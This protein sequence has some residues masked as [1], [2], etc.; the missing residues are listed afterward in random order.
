MCP[1][2]VNDLQRRLPSERMGKMTLLILVLLYTIQPVSLGWSGEG[3]DG[4]QS[5][6]L[7]PFLLMI[8]SAIVTRGG[9]IFIGHYFVANRA[10]NFSVVGLLRWSI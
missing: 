4:C 8:L 3:R 7:H 6:N 9:L 2:M 5:S 10:M 1:G